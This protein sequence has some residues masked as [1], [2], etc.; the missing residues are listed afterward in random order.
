MR[1]VVAADNPAVGS[2]EVIDKRSQGPPS[3][4]PYHS[5]EA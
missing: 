4:N 2:S 3:N 1:C 5:S